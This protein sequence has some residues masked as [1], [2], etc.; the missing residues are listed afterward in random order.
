[1]CH[2]NVAPLGLEYKMPSC[3]RLAVLPFSSRGAIFLV[4]RACSKSN[5]CEGNNL[6]SFRSHNDWN[7]IVA[8]KGVPC[9]RGSEGS[10]RQKSDMTNRNR[11]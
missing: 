5:R 11:I 4:C 3:S 8:G 1:M 9:E 7:P 10:C 6:K 2:K